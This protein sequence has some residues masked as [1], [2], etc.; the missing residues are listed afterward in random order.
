MA[1]PLV[2]LQMRRVQWPTG[3]HNTNRPREPLGHRRCCDTC[4]APHLPGQSHAVGS[5]IVFW[6]L[7]ALW[8]RRRL[9]ADGGPK[10]HAA[11]RKRMD[12][13]EAK[14]LAEGLL[15]AV[16]AAARVQMR[17]FGAGL[18]VERK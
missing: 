18:T 16:L 8:S 7:P 12:A 14:S 3:T 9:L 4:S 2:L 5:G 15:S 1:G 13:K 17:H 10:T 11:S 6:S